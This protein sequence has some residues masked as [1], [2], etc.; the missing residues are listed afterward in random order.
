MSLQIVYGR[1]GTGKT[2]Y[3]FQEISRNINNGR[4]KYIIT[5]EQFSFSAEKELLKSL[6]A[7][8][9]AVINAE[10]LT[11]ARMAHRVSGEVGGSNKTVLSN[12]GK[13]MLIYS[14][15]ANKKNNLKFLGKSDSNIDMIMTQI[16]ELKKHGVTLENLKDLVEEVGNTDT[17]LDTKLNDIYTVY[18][19]FQE[20]ITDN[21]IDENDSLTIL[22]QQLSATDMFK[23]TEIYI[24]E[25]VGFTK[26]EYDIIEKLLQVARSVVITV[27][28]DGMYK[29]KEA[30][31]DIFYSNKETIEKLLKLAKSLKVKIEEPIFLDK[32]LRF[33]SEE[34]K[35]I[36][37]NLYNF[38][39]RKYNGKTESIR[40]FLANNQYSE[41]E[42]V[43]RRIVELIR[44]GKYRYR[45][46]AVITKNI[47]V[48]SNLCKAIFKKYDIPVY[49]DEKRDLSQ[50]ILVKYL[51]SILDVF[52][53]NWAYD[54]V[55]N[56][57][58]CGFLDLTPDEI[59]LLENYALKWEV[60]G[61]KWYKEDWNFHDE[62]EIGKDAINNINEIRKK[63]VNP[64][65]KLKNNLSGNKTAKQIS[66]NLYNFFIENGIDKILEE[67]VKKLNGIGK[68]N[69]AAEYETS[70]KV[71]MQVLDEIVLVFGE[72]NITFENYMQILKTGLGESKLG[73]I[74]MAQDEVTVGDVDRSRSHKIKV[75]F[76]IGLND[77]MFPSVNKAEGF[78]NDDDREKIKQ[79]GVELAKGTI[80]RIYEDNFN[81]YKA[82]TTA[83]EKI[84][85][86]YSSSDM[87]GKSLRP[88][89]L[90]SRIKKIFE[91][92]EE[93]SDIVNRKS[94]ISTVESTFEEL[95]VNLREFR[96]GKEIP[97]IWFNI[98][99]IYNEN[100]EWHDKLASAVRGLNYS[101]VP[102]K[103]T[104]ENIDKIYGNT[105]RTSVSRLE[106]YS[107]CPFSYFLKYG[108]KLNDKE[109]FKVESVDTGSFMHD[110]ID[111]F[112]GIIEERN[113]ILKRLT[114]EELEPIVSEIVED[115]LKLNRNYIFTTTAKYKVLAQR[116]KKVVTMSIKYIVQTIKQSEFE[117]FGHEVEFGGKGQYKPITIT[118]AEGKKVEIIGKI[119]RVDILRNP[120]G[121]YV[122]IIDYKS[123]IKN[124]DL[125][126]VM[127]GLQ[128]QLLTYLNETCKVEDFI[129]AGVLYFNLS[130]PTIGTDKNM[131]N[132][133]IE[134][135]IKQEF[136]MKGLI[137]ADVNIVKKMDTNIENEPKG[138]S[139][140]I[141]A[142]IKKDGELS[143][144]GTSAVTR[145]QFEYLQ[146]YMEKIITQISEGILGGNIEVK[147]YYNTGNKKTPC[148]YC[149]YKS[150]CRFDENSKGNRYNYLTNL[151]KEAIMELIKEDI[152]EK[153]F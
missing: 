15:L 52:S 112:F 21:Y 60:K 31:N 86:S 89:V 47:D 107:G 25:F 75:T 16:T 84:Y 132:E 104:K 115:K 138:V 43:A 30:S 37:R 92:I 51:I 91:K 140:I 139:K 32:I 153:K 22:A 10:V 125:N 127:S 130:N 11:F 8:G 7:Q 66:E 100:E 85:L 116:L 49:I 133:E 126:Q 63:V 59:Y 102:E 71:V 74:P 98:Y 128:L 101:N 67:K 65:V 136:K 123:S 46:I 68:V 56:Y 14:I 152:Q 113:I 88:S 135:K 99:N 96:D 73:T 97:E 69:I 145:E 2:N 23:N 53:K 80:D 90:I 87:E 50:N 103:I 137:L 38:P 24:D 78:L 36:E 58:K 144:K 20:R 110:I 105:L 19:K 6:E 35:H 119:D 44:S 70:W 48:Y 141:P 108:L 76:I 149:K 62:E 77:G 29:D 79:N 41:I 13:S 57:I 120:D 54:S 42:E 61:S 39:Y 94:E 147:P 34:L 117:V 118:T 150:I 111:N 3:I 143:S 124:I 1:S 26:Q 5:P 95:L 81:I 146:R 106:Q 129:P 142:T 12:C 9:S 4:K 134:E 28:S 72:E 40:L 17:Y 121:T 45:D 151:N 83:E 131:S 82:F 55:F 109:T 114:E 27:S 93:E 18:S 64:L 33:K 148:E 122:R